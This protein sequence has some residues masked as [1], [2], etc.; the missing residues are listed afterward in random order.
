MSLAAGSAQTLFLR[1]TTLALQVP[2]SILLA[3]LLGVEGKGS[4]TLLTVIPWL[5]A[6]VLMGGLD[7]AQTYLL[8][9]RKTTLRAVSILAGWATPVI[10]IL[11]AVVYLLFVAPSVLAGVPWGLVLVSTVLI[12]LV[13]FR[14]FLLSVLLGFER[15]V[16]FNLIY[17]VNSFMVLLFVAVLAGFLGYGLG[18]A[19]AAFIITQALVLPFGL[20]W[21]RRTSGAYRAGGEKKDGTRDKKLTGWQHLTRSLA[22]GLKGHP[23]VVL[24]T[25]NQ[26]FDIFLLGAMAGPKEVG[27]YAVAVAMAEV[28]WHVPMSVHL[29]LFPR[30]AADGA[31]EGVKRLPRACRMIVLLSVIM[32]LALVLIGKPAIR[33]LFGL[34]FLP[35]SNAMFALLPGIVAVSA[36]RV[37]ESYFSGVDRRHYQSISASFSF[38]LALVLCIVLIPRYGALGAALAS[39]AGYTLQM[40]ISIALFT[41]IGTLSW[42][43]FFLPHRGDIEYLVT[44]FRQLISKRT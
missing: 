30:V 33:I 38:A 14:Y 7:T 17:L 12:P 27:L 21:I 41:R 2:T 44:T 31:D 8:S 43:D 1:L 18:G 34:S 24:T 23:A 42:K 13:I 5:T 3:R 19:L 29:N 28:I 10:A 9:S 25:F 35:A 26:R 36:A 37:F 32:A 22:Y 16:L 40:V 39:T 15:V 6:Y 4:Y 20:V 11:S